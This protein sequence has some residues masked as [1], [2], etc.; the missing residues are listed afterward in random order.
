METIINCKRIVT[1][2]EAISGHIVVKDSVISAVEQGRSV[3]AGAL[4]WTD[5]VLV[6]GLIDIHTDNLEKHYMP[7][8]GAQW[9][10]LGAAIAHDGQMATAGVTTVLDSLSLHG[11]STHGLNRSDALADLI[12][13]L[14]DG[15]AHQA[16][17]V[18]HRLHLRCEVTNPSLFDLLE[19]YLGTNRLQMLS[20]MDHTPGARHPGGLDAVKEKWRRKGMSQDE[21]SERLNRQG[22]WRDPAGAAERRAKVAALGLQHGLPVASHDDGLPEHIDEAKDLGCTIAEFP[23]TAEAATRAHEVGM[24]NV[25]GAPNFVRG[26][27]HG[28]NLSARALAATRELDAL[29]SDY[30]PQSMIR[31]AFMLTEEPFGWSLSEALATVT[32]APA[33]MSNLNDR[34]V[35]EVGKRADIVRVAHTPGGWPVIR[36]VWR[37]GARVA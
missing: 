27:S 5:E 28:D 1:T 29:C 35:I 20:A 18:D 17:R 32:A 12:G 19:D 24:V 37:G 8:P 9:D 26:R 7:R 2:D 36:E 3:A 16:F 14:D 25:M 33:A 22:N 23:I 15:D 10:R 34:G 30:V 4:D 11:R 21:I 6:P 31:A 13:A